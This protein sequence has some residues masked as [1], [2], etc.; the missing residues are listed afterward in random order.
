M[1]ISPDAAHIQVMSALFEEYE[2]QMKAKWDINCF[3]GYAA[4]MSSRSDVY[5]QGN[6]WL[7]QS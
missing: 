5:H 3:H 6:L 7:E 4:K 2:Y 1:V